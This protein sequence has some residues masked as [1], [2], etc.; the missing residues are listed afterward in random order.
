V[1]DRSESQSRSTVPP[2]NASALLRNLAIDAGLPWVALQLMQ[3]V[4]HVPLVP[5]LAA[6]SIFPAA[7]IVVSWV[8]QHRVDFIGLA[9]LVTILGGIAVA[10]MTEDPRYAVLKAAP[11]FGLFGIACLLSLVRRRPL[12]F[13][14]SREF[15][16]GGDEAQRAAWTARL[17]NPGF[18]HAMRRLTLVWGIAC[19]GEAVLG[20]SVAFLLPPAL[21]LVVEPALGIGTVAGLL[22][23]TFAY[24]RRRQAAAARSDAARPARAD[25]LPGHIAR[26]ISSGD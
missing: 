20:I 5:A 19:V 9:V 11:G 12:M 22:T 15:T 21:A 13:F 2:T 25:P 17:E 26:P 4:W 16:T 1:T 10:L 8:R 3:R 24:G 14:V 23:W 18:R 6:A 7:S